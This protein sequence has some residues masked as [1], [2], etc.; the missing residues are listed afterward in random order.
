MDFKKMSAPR[1]FLREVSASTL[2]IVPIC[3][4]GSYTEVIEHPMV[5][6]WVTVMGFRRPSQ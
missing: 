6:L 2:L 1:S 5:D 3:V 4:V